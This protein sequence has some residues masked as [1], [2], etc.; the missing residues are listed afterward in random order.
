MRILV[1]DGNTLPGLAITR[2]L[3]KAGHEVF[4]GH[5]KPSSLAAYSRYAKGKCVYP[6][7][8]NSAQEF[9][10]YLITYATENQIDAIF[11]VTDITT[12]PVT[13]HRSEFPSTCSIPCAE[14]KAVAEA[15]DKSRI[16]QLADSLGVDIPGS[17]VIE[18]CKD[19]DPDLIELDFPLVIKPSRSRVLRGSR[20]ILTSV[21]YAQDKDDLIRQLK[22]FEDDIFPVIL[23]ERIQGPGLGVFMCFN[24]GKPIASFSHKRLREKPPS[25]GVSVLRE[26]IPVDPLAYDFSVKLLSALNWHGVAMVE[27]KVS[28]ADQRPKLMEINGRFWGSLQLSIDSGL[29]FPKL[30]A[31][32]IESTDV[33]PVTEYKYGIKTR[34]LWGDIDAL[35][36]RMLKSNRSL[37]LPDG[38]DGKLKYLLKFLIFWQPGMHYDVLK[39]GDPMPWFYETVQWFRR[40]FG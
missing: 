7:P 24:K 25:G 9:I 10:Q 39:P 15:A 37:N 5:H 26:S 36:I 6:D 20:W 31:Q 18:S 34:W 32:S 8:L 40:L 28:N 27:F 16:L 22:A 38:A 14:Y 3:G 12:L 1:T 19:L 21:T 29:N 2:S 17:H 33:A 13:Q 30:L 4:V 35:L 23:Q 11:P